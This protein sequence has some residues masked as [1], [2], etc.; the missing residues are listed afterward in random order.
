MVLLAVSRAA[1]GDRGTIDHRDC[2]TFVVDGETINLK[3]KMR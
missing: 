1:Q 2:G 3:P